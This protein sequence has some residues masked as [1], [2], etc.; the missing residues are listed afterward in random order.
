MCQG[1]S[2]NIFSTH[3]HSRLE[4]LREAPPYEVRCG[5]R[6]IHMFLVQ[7]G[8]VFANGVFASLHWGSSGFI[9]SFPW[10]Y[11]KNV[12]P[13]HAAFVICICTLNILWWLV[14]LVM[15]IAVLCCCYLMDFVPFFKTAKQFNFSLLQWLVVRSH[16][17]KTSII[18]MKP[19]GHTPVWQCSSYPADN[20]VNMFPSPVA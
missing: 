8:D 14:V 6:C 18:L 4:S 3:D 5:C 7:F 19:V 20:Q 2:K 17:K 1:L 16:V 13:I 10:G 9:W 12:C 11:L 15:D